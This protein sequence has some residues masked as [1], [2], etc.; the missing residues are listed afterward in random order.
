MTK[1]AVWIVILFHLQL[2]SIA[3]GHSQMRCAK[4]NKSTGKCDAAVRNEG[5]TLMR[6][7]YLYTEGAPICQDSWANP[8]SSYY[9]NGASCPDWAPCPTKM[10]SYS[11]GEAFTVMWFARNHAV[12][13]Q[14]PATVSLYMSPKASANQASDVSSSVMKQNTICKGP[15]MNCN[16]K[17]GNEDPCTLDCTIPSNTA[18][19]IYTLWWK[20]D[21][22]GVMYATCADIN[23]GGTSIPTPPPSNPT[24]TTTTTTTTGKSSTTTTGKSSTTTTTT[25]GKSSTTTT[26]GKS[27]S[28]STGSKP[29][30]TGIKNSGNLCYLPDTPFLQN[31]LH[32]SGKCG[33]RTKTRCADG[34]CCS[35]AGYCGSTSLYCNNN[36]ADYRKYECDSL[37]QGGIVQNSVYA[38]DY[39]DEIQATSSSQLI[40]FNNLLILFSSIM[41]GFITYYI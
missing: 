10:G 31:Q 34:Q 4:W 9:A 32:R 21:W 40:K 37:P 13:D 16:G 25:T 14:S 41:V 12:A 20:W 17:F 22:Q 28:T 15:Y 35:S 11:A 38:E 36:Q 5:F 27:S 39:I 6:E 33:P 29:A 2:V 30:T 18:N 26:T 7:S 1:I 8:I 3:L 23:V 19:G 24:T